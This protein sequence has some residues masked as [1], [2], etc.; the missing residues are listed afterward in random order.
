MNRNREAKSLTFW[1]GSEVSQDSNS[2]FAQ[3]IQ[4]AEFLNGPKVQ[5]SL[6]KQDGTS[7]FGA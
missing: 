6:G 4:S 3:R 1:R 7:R 5:S 2:A